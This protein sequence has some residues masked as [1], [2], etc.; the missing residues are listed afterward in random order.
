MSP[1][2]ARHRTRER[3]LCY[4]PVRHP[5][6]GLGHAMTNLKCLMMEA[7]ALGRL[8]IVPPLNLSRGHN[9]GTNLAWRWEKYFD[10]PAGRLVDLE[11]GSSQAIPVATHPPASFGTSLTVSLRRRVPRRAESVELIIRRVHPFHPNS[12]PFSIRPRTVRLWLP[13]SAAAA[14]LAGPVIERLRSLPHGY[15]AVHVRRGDRLLHDRRWAD[16]TTP[17]RVCAKLRDHGIGRDTPVYIL[18]NERDPAFWEALR[19]CCRMYRHLDFPH[20]AAVVSQEDGQHPDNYLLFVAEWE[21]MQHA[22]LRIGTC[23]GPE[24]P[25]ADDWLDKGMGTRNVRRLVR[26]SRQALRHW[27]SIPLA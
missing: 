10:L 27:S 19:G 12:V 25:Q 22:R 4:D 17:E 5:P 14:E 24:K 7:V 13:P 2:Q 16:A 21:I 3:Y 11:S 23:W 1:H 9:A 26:R 20:L 6:H 18:S 15:V 8:G